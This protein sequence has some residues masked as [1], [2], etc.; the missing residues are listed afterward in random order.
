MH[1]KRRWYRQRWWYP[2]A[3]MWM[4][5]AGRGCQKWINVDWAAMIKAMEGKPI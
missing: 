3:T 2:A 5:E 1:P 4:P